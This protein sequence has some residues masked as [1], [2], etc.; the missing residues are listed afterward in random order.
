[1]NHQNFSFKAT[2]SALTNATTTTIAKLTLQNEVL[3]LNDDIFGL[4]PFQVIS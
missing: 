1:M 2:M 3:S 4:T